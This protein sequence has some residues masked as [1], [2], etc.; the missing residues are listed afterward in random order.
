MP[1]GRFGVLDVDSCG[2]VHEFREKPSTEVG[3]INGGFMVLSPK[4]LDYIEGDDTT[5]EKEPLANLAA[6]RQLG[7]HLHTGFWQA[8][9]TLRDKRYL[10]ELWSSGAAPWKSW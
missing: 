6:E 10:E 3:W 7:V 9:D 8:M 5:F 2:L 1:P 4:V